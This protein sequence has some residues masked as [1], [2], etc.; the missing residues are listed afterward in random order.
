MYI[1]CEGCVSSLL[2]YLCAKL[3]ISEQRTKGKR[4]FLCFF[5]CNATLCTFRSENES[6]FS[7]GEKYEKKVS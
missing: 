3:R 7:K 6:N 4:V 1:C 5:D 2:R